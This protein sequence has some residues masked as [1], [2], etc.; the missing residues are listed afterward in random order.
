MHPDISRSAAVASRLDW[1]DQS[2]S[3]NAELARLAREQSAE[4]PD[5][6][7]VVTDT[8]TAGRGR[9]DRVWTSPPGS[10]LAIS[11][12]LRPRL[13]V[14]SLGWLPLVGGLAMT[15]AVRG[16]L[17]DAGLDASRARIKWPNDVLVGGRKICGVLSE[18]VEVADEGAVVVL[19]AGVNTAMTVE[20]LPVGTATSLVA[21]GVSHVSADD[22]LGRYLEELRVL[23]DALANAD[24]DAVKSGV[25]QAVMDA[26]A[27]IGASVRVE[28][29][30]ESLLTGTAVEIDGSGRLVVR[31][32]DG[33][34]TAV[35]A[36][37]VVHLLPL[38]P[39]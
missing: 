36:G 30:G 16:V 20:Q 11:V 12:L 15:R 13:P 1:R 27:T 9:R 18:L 26:C 25:R 39:S 5:F 2:P 37:D 24:G 6:S 8:Q 19:G 14:A 34:L 33:A 31:S 38:A 7:V 17:A 23:Y 35:S 22:V 32:G 3:T 21:E 4:W 10:S 28:L 29:P